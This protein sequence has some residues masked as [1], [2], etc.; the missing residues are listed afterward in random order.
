MVFGGIFK[1]ISQFVCNVVFL[2]TIDF[3]EQT[4]NFSWNTQNKEVNLQKIND[5]SSHGILKFIL[6]DI[7][8]DLLICWHV[9]PQ[10]TISEIL[11]MTSFH[12]VFNSVFNLQVL[13]MYIIINLNFSPHIACGAFY[14]DKKSDIRGKK[15]SKWKQ[16]CKYMLVHVCR[17]S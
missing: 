15:M 4:L 9:L 1:L 7:K 6:S 2:K 8:F 12:S 5:N 11:K 16:S 10:V 17:N 13:Y 14:F 3:V